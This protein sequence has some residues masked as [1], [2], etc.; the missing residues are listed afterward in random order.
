M[1]ER[2]IRAQHEARPDQKLSPYLVVQGA[3]QAIEF[4]TRAFGAEEHYRL[5]EPSGKVGHA[6]LSIGGT[7]IML[8]D[9]YP[10]FGALSPPSVGGSP[11][12]LHLFVDDVDAVVAHAVELGATL[13]RQVKLE[14]FG[15]RSGLLVDPFGHRWHLATR[16]EVVAPAEMQRRWSQMFE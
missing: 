11:V 8:A 13:V 1:N 16:V 2:A 3:A 12:T 15:D 10:D 5:T 9:E 4:Y 14:F 6:E 7:R